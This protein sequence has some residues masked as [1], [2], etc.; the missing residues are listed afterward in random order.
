MHI[1]SS[2]YDLFFVSSIQPPSRIGKCA[3]GLAVYPP[4]LAI[5]FLV[6]FLNFAL[7]IFLPLL[8]FFGKKIR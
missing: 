2:R 8:Y 6:I 3:V 1:T 7:E 4:N 5:N